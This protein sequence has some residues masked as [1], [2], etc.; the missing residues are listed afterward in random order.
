MTSPRSQ[1]ELKNFRRS[2]C[3]EQVRALRDFVTRTEIEKERA[4]LN[5]AASSTVFKFRPEAACPPC[6][7]A[8]PKMSSV[9]PLSLQK[10]RSPLATT[11]IVHR[12]LLPDRARKG[13]PL[14]ASITGASRGRAAPTT[15]WDYK[16]FAAGGQ[17]VARSERK[18]A[19]QGSSEHSFDL[20]DQKDLLS[21]YTKACKLREATNPFRF[22]LELTPRAAGSCD[23]SAVHV[24]PSVS[25]QHHS[26]PAVAAVSSLNVALDIMRSRATPIPAPPMD[27][28]G[29]SEFFLRPGVKTSLT[30]GGEVPIVTEPVKS[31]TESV[32]DGRRTK[33]ASIVASP[34]MAVNVYFSTA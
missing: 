31:F 1:S 18:E 23:V 30:E 26:S 4:L 13:R 22:V 10:D 15:A 32:A 16:S 7:S 21:L 5:A 27:S 28:R 2:Q 14:S 24:V 34:S 9:P 6:S 11:R 29:S 20:L 3:A 33:A 12:P 19:A 17:A 8:E 25:L